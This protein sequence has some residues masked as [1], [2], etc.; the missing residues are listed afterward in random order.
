MPEMT[1]TSPIEKSVKEIFQKRLRHGSAVSI[2]LKKFDGNLTVKSQTNRLITL[3]SIAIL[4]YFP[5]SQETVGT[6]FVNI[7]I[8][9]F[10]ATIE[11]SIKCTSGRSSMANS[12]LMLQNF[13][14]PTLSQRGVIY[15]RVWDFLAS[16]CCSFENWEWEFSMDYER[17]PA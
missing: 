7:P 13:L 10:W 6:C 16:G 14:E 2:A 4:R 15:L 9:K 12:S 5:G 1:R 3:V 17:K 11:T 8:A